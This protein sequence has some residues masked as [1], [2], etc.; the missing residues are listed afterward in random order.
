MPLKTEGGLL[1]PLTTSK[2]FNLLIQVLLI[3]IGLG[4]VLGTAQ[5]TKTLRMD[6]PA[7]HLHKSSS[8]IPAE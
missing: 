8:P 5:Y 3:I 1:L 2:P 4:K 6:H 7:T